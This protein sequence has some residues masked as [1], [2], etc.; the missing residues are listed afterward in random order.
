MR[1]LIVVLLL[2]PAAVCAAGKQTLDDGWPAGWSKIGPAETAV[3][4]ALGLGT[5][6]MEVVVKPPSLPRWDT[7]AS[8]TPRPAAAAS[9]SSSAVPEGASILCRWCIS[10]ISTS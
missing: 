8:G 10:T 3:I 9:P 2:A 5:L 1:A 4:G 7:L 6:L